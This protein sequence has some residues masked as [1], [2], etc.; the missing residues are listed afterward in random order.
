MP[1]DVHLEL[2]C[3]PAN[4]AALS[5]RIDEMLAVTRSFRGCMSAEVRWDLDRP[6]CMVL[7]ERWT[8]RL[9]HEEYV[10][11]RASNGDNEEL[12]PMFTAPPVVR[13]LGAPSDGET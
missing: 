8:S 7:L 6:E 4:R 10:A 11:W 12:L 1:I 9:A 2:T 3:A 5:R 13:Y